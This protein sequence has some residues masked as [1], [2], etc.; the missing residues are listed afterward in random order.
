MFLFFILGVFVGAYGLAVFGL[1]D[2]DLSRI[3]AALPGALNSL[4][5]TGIAVL[6]TTFSFVFVALSL[7]SVQFSTRV[8]RQF[9]H[10]DPFRRFFLWAYIGIFAACFLIQFFDVP[11][12]QFLFAVLG[13][14]LIFVIFPAFLTYLAN[15]LNAATIVQSIARRTLIEIIDQ[16]EPV[17]SANADGDSDKVRS[18]K[19]GYLEHID[20]AQLSAEFARVRKDHPDAR[21]IVSNYL[22]SFVE[23]S[24]KLAEITPRVGLDRR[25][26]SALR[27]CFHMG[28]FRSIDQDI[29]Y[30]IRQLVDIAIKAISPAVNDPTTCINCL[31]YLGVIIKS[32]ALRDS[33]SITAKELEKNGIIIREPEFERYVNDAFDQI[34]QWGRKDYIVIRALLNTLSDIISVITDGAKCEIIARQVEDMELGHLI[35][36]PVESPIGLK[37]HRNSLR[38]SLKRFYST[39]ARQFA[40]SGR[41][42]REPFFRQMDE[43]IAA[44]ME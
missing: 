9:W 30:G 25:T 19:S 36:K 34:Y 44:S 32:L 6:V 7:V 5:A 13:F 24:S 42:D 2:G 11:R 40:A 17:A 4:V 29:G 10:S 22:G 43:N 37:E 16:Y 35:D 31:H 39:A 3:Y 33:R 8:V 12:V 21:L 27:R 41:P 23:V 15:N 1:S 26:E 38:R 18:K 28:R 14:Y 20:T